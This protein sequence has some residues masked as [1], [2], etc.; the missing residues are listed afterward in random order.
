MM[1]IYFSLVSDIAAYISKY[2][3]IQA[4]TSLTE[5]EKELEIEKLRMEQLHRK[6]IYTQLLENF[7]TE[8]MIVKIFPAS[9]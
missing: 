1:L 6:A 5:K 9:W 7:R 3:L 4:N 2:N 8:E